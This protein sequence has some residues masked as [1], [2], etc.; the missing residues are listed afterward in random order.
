[1]N[2]ARILGGLF[3]L[4]VIAV[5]YAWQATPRQERVA[6]GGKVVRPPDQ[7][8]VTAEQLA[9]VDD[10]NFASGRESVYSPP[11]RDLF[12][13]IYKAPKRVAAKPKPT[14][15]PVAVQPAPKPVVSPETVMVQPQLKPIPS[16]TILGYLGK[17]GERTV[18]LSSA[19]GEIY[20]VKQG[21]DFGED[22]YVKEISAGEITIGQWQTGRQVVLRV[23]ET[24]TQRLPRMKLDS[25]RQMFVPPETPQPGA[26]GEA[27]QPD[28]KTKE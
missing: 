17:G 14:P 8:V 6:A 27:P 10:L 9:T 28:T 15:K 3:L 21:D 20:L 16:L 11:A 18:F 22:L 4:L 25:G 1:M 2:R 13:P 26:A 12:G 5:I 24:K 19:Q 23:S 7:R